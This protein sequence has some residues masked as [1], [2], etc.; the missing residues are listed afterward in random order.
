MMPEAGSARPATD[1]TYTTNSVLLAVSE[2]RSLAG[3]T[4][5]LALTSYGER[6]GPNS[7]IYAN[8]TFNFLQDYP[9]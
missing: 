6:N 1:L 8:S 5:C 3:S 2:A 7:S 9:Q 4:R